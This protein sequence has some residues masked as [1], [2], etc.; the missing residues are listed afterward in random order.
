A[1]T[2]GGDEISG[3]GGAESV[4]VDHRLPAA[5]YGVG[6]RDHFGCVEPAHGGSAPA[7]FP[8]IP[9]RALEIHHH[10]HAGCPDRGGHADF[11][12]DADVDRS[13]HPPRCAE[14]SATTAE[15]RVAV[16][17]QRQLIWWRFK[18]HKL[19]LVSGVIVALFYFVSLFADTIAYTEPF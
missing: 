7:A 4:R 18:K 2:A 9:G 19:A 8:P 14:M 10:P 5:L 12:S 13:P 6:Q 17:T 11:G 3:A 16:A 15:N 1:G